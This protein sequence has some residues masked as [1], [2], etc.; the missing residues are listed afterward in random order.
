MIIMRIATITGKK[1][2]GKTRLA[3]YLA[4]S[5]SRRFCIAFVKHIHHPGELLDR[6]G[7][8]TYRLT[9][10][11][12]VTVVGVSPDALFLRTRKSEED[13]DTALK[14]IQDASPN[15][16]LIL[17]EGFYR[18]LSAREGIIRIYVSQNE[19]DA[20]SIAAQDPR[21]SI[22]YCEKCSFDKA[23]GIPVAKHPQ[24]ILV[25]LERALEREF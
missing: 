20:L 15:C 18:K 6:E 22:I 21:P 13:I 16:D 5:L 2:S 9:R 25:L 8:D 24:D 19:E 1:K 14:L 23:G 10:A 3:E 11:G 12:A 17:I 4:S 7:S